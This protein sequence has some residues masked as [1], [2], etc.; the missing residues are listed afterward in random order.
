[1]TSI[2]QNI[3][4]SD[5]SS[6]ISKTAK[7]IESNGN[8]ISSNKNRKTL[9]ILQE[10][11]DKKAGNKKTI[12]SNTLIS[13]ESGGFAKIFAKPE[14]ASNKCVGKGFKIYED[15]DKGVVS[16]S[17][18][19][20]LAISKTF[21]SACTQTKLTGNDLID[22]QSTIQPGAEFYKELAEKRREALDESL[23]E[24]E[25][26]WIENEEQRETVKTLEEKVSSLEDTVEKARKIT[27]I[28]E[29]YLN[30]DIENDTPVEDVSKEPNPES[31]TN[32]NTPEKE[33]FIPNSN[34]EETTEVVNTDKQ[35]NKT[36]PDDNKKDN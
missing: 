28:L 12:G 13:R 24:N 20:T 9:Q 16:T 17:S 25:R 31:E 2:G 21:L 3:A 19:Q 35:K 29:P 10:K 11:N 33:M 5:E 22:L 4:T 27:E 32:S 34:T 8:P 26:L 1:M 15:E 6:E 7:E 14:K 18:S 30:E 36:M 23:N